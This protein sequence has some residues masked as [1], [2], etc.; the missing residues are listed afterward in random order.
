MRPATRRLSSLRDHRGVC[1]PE[2]L[3][4]YRML[5]PGFAYCGEG[6]LTRARA[7]RAVEAPK[8]RFR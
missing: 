1:L 4:E 5:R 6:A 3:E 7:D 2:T 8:S